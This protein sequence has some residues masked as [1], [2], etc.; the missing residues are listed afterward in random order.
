M[1]KDLAQGETAA[2]PFEGDKFAAYTFTS[3]MFDVATETATM[4]ELQRHIISSDYSITVF[5]QNLDGTPTEE[6]NKDLSNILVGIGK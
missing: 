5:E 6:L 1:N 4:D 3:I 2:F